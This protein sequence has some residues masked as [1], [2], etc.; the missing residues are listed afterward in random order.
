MVNEIS[1]KQV[2][3][4]KHKGKQNTLT[5]THTHPHTHTLH[6]SQAVY[7]VFYCSQVCHIYCRSIRH[8]K[9]KKKKQRPYG[10]FTAYYTG[11][12]IIFLQAF[13]ATCDNYKGWKLW[14]LHKAGGGGGGGFEPGSVVS[15]MVSAMVSSLGETGDSSPP[16]F[17]L[18]LMIRLYSSSSSA[19]TESN[20][21]WGG[22]RTSIKVVFA[23]N[24]LRYE[25]PWTKEL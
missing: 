8:S 7:T 1:Q 21:F 24:T 19:L 5:L 6:P 17:S 23:F 15:P 14:T 9:K 11:G 20:G 10:T 4:K 18:L 3:L 22:E 25:R 16:P 12:K 13:S 2:S